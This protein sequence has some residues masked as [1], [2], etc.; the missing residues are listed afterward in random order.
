M[1]RKPMTPVTLPW[2]LEAV[3]SLVDGKPGPLDLD[4]L[5]ITDT[6]M[7]ALVCMAQKTG[8]VVTI[9]QAA[10]ALGVT[11]EQY[12]DIRGAIIKL[13]QELTRRMLEGRSPSAAVIE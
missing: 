3:R 9:D 2:T 11:R 12:G 7:L 1:P 13:G 10:R 6:M 8:S 4:E 5:A